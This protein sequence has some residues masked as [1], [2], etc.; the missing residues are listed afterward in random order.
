[1]SG[2]YK[3]VIVLV[4]YIT[5]LAHLFFCQ[6]ISD[7]L[8]SCLFNNIMILCYPNNVSIKIVLE[9]KKNI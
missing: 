2:M 7:G 8:I 5:F 6:T 3:I 1:M 4:Y 9:K